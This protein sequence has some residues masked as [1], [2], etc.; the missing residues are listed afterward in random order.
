M[1][2]VPLLLKVVDLELAQTSA[3]CWDGNSSIDHVLDFCFVRAAFLR[4]F[5]RVR[6]NLDFHS[7]ILV[8]DGVHHHPIDLQYPNH[9]IVIYFAWQTPA[10]VKLIHF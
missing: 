7:S 9:W 3:F 5:Q 2:V 6:I 4:A 10:W 8:R 1:L